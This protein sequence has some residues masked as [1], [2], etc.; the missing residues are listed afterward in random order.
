[1]DFRN[2]FSR[3]T[4]GPRYELQIEYMPYRKKLINQDTKSQTRTEKRG[5]PRDNLITSLHLSS[6]LIQ[7]ILE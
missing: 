4:S 1:M 6:V 5:K 3:E 2:L 7:Y